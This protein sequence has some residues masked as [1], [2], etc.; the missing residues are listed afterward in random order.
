[1]VDLPFFHP[2]SLSESQLDRLSQCAGEAEAIPVADLLL[3]ARVHLERT[4]IAHS[5][6]RLINV[7]LAAAIVGVLEELAGCCNS[8][9]VNEIWWVKGAMHYFAVSNDD[10]PDFQSPLGFEDDGEILNACLK[11]IGRNDLC[12]NAEDYDNA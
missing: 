12:L 4:H 11:Y 10:E 2:D 6:N 8:L 1:M 9:K 7:R 5:A 3:A